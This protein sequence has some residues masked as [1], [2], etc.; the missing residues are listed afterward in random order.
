MM[1]YVRAEREADWPLHILAVKL[2]LP[3][4]FAAGH[5][6]YTRYGLYY[7]R[8][9]EML[10]CKVNAEGTRNATHSGYLECH[11][12]QYVYRDDIHEIWTRT[13]RNHWK[14]PKT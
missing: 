9:M 1:V 12:E 3:Y 6:N 2:M 14:Y 7:L 13:T 5:V 11:L 8:S 4:F 10:P